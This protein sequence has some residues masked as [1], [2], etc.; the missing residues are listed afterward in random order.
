M[1]VKDLS[2]TTTENPRNTD[3]KWPSFDNGQ[4]SRIS[5]DLLYCKPLKI[6]WYCIK[7]PKG[8]SIGC[9]NVKMNVSKGQSQVL[10]CNVNSVVKKYFPSLFNSSFGMEPG[11]RRL[12]FSVRTRNEF[13]ERYS[14]KK[15]CSVASISKFL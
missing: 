4:E 14:P 6:S 10:Y 7:P 9:N 3:I 13:G 5:Y 1:D 12:C 15:C 11:S 2:C 8:Y